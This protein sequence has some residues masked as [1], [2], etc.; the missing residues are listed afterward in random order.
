MIGDPLVIFYLATLEQLIVSPVIVR[1]N[2]C[3]HMICCFLWLYRLSKSLLDITESMMTRAHGTV[4]GSHYCC[5]DRLSLES[6]LQQKYVPWAY[7]PEHV[8]LWTLVIW[9]TLKIATVRLWVQ[10]M[11]P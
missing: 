5:Q 1:Y 11:S 7:G 6:R 2:I 10:V 4:E 8:G 3:I 9:A